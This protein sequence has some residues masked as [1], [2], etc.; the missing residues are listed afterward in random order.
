M[1]SRNDR[2]KWNNWLVFCVLVCNTYTIWYSWFAME[3][4]GEEKFIS[5]PWPL[6]PE[7]IVLH[8]SQKNLGFWSTHLKLLHTG[9][10]RQVSSL[11]WSSFF[12]C[13]NLWWNN[14]VFAD[15]TANKFIPNLFKICVNIWNVNISLGF[16][17]PICEVRCLK[18]KGRKRK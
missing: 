13:I 18:E 1:R 10:E 11:S 3:T 15:T 9:Y 6:N 7:I 2:W 8:F 16:A 17:L 12:S 4:T 14:W 5:Y